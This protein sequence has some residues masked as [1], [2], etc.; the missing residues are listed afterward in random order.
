MNPLLGMSPILARSTGS[1]CP[2]FQAYS[3]SSFR[4][5]ST[6]CIAAAAAC[7]SSGSRRA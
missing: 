5:A 2:D 7:A 1:R 6:R 3:K 4:E